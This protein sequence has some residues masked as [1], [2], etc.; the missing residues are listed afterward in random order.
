MND[1]ISSQADKFECVHSITRIQNVLANFDLS[2]FD[3]S[4][5]D[6]SNLYYVLLVE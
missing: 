3:L 5:F 4:N 1:D 6:L 2:N